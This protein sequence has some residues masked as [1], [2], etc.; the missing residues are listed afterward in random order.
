MKAMA[1]GIAA[2]IAIFA[3]VPAARATEASPLG[4]ALELLSS[5]EAKVRSEGEEALKTYTAAAEWCEERSKTLGYEIKTGKA[6]MTDVKATVEAES[7]AM[8][9]FE[10]KV[11]QLAGSIAKSE[12]DL[13][14]ATEIR[15]KESGDF[16]S[17][18][19]ELAETISTLERSISILEREAQRGGASALQLR[20]AGSVAH[21]M[22][23]L[24]EAS[25]L[26]TADAKQLTALVQS[27]QRSAADS[28]EA[29]LGAPDAA[30]YEGHSQGIIGTLED[31]LE[32][33]QSQLTEARTR[34]TSSL[35]NF[36]MLKQSLEDEIK[37]ASKGMAEAKQKAAGSREAKATAEGDLRVTAGEL[38]EDTKALAELRHDCMSKAQDF[39][40]AKKD[41]SE[42][43]KALIEASKV[44]Q[45]QTGAA[46]KVSYDFGQVSLAQVARAG[47]SSPGHQA[48]R[49]VRELARAQ[50]STG[51]AQLA[52]RMAV[53]T[54]SELLAGE[55]PFAK[56][57][58]L[59][60]DM[61]AK[62]EGEADA[63]A[64]HKAYCDKEI[65][66]AQEKKGEKATKIGRLSTKIDRMTSRVAE[67]QAQISALHKGL[68]DLARTQAEMDQLR[69]QE[70]ADYTKNKA[71]MQDGIEGVKVALKVLREY[72]AQDSNTASTG[73]GA[74]II[75]L[76]EVVES[77]FSKSLTEMRAE[78]STS[79][80]A[81]DQETKENEIEKTTKEQDVKHKSK[82]VAGLEKELTEAEGDKSMERS[83]LEA[84]LESLR[85]LEKQCV[86][87][88]ATFEE[89]KARFEAE[90]AGLRQA[91]AVL[92][93]EAVLLQRGELH[94][95]RG[96]RPHRGAA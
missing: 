80:A 42:E 36:E 24:V 23:L 34:E 9:S 87:Q 20:N 2:L 40:A 14:A 6:E 66:E 26:T 51:L 17:E 67:L 4:K 95:L 90:L 5:L 15:A 82:E 73:A 76:L 74:G 91:L 8:A 12:A 38:K 61:V 22:G 16:A 94:A 29:S 3:V 10:T 72:Y 86:A 44:L 60:T 11:D 25:A 71:N 39:E 63:E 77:D 35:Q 81:Y 28:S 64:S 37:Y 68:S 75:G 62:L 32:K 49:L 59:I 21:V 30:A 53:A 65:A 7:A 43:L 88:P 57:K 50:H 45:D 33:A 83:E 69:Q 19:K 46:A 52:A 48:V 70:K 56:V 93:G 41:R 89:R 18:E 1:S 96:V 13:K 47:A 58:G 85:M 27:S 55:D 54:H 78:E 31:L 84:T 92:D 79:A